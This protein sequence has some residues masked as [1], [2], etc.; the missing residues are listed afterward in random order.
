VVC[1]DHTKRPRTVLGELVCRFGNYLARVFVERTPRRSTW[2]A[3]PSQ[4]LEAARS[5][6]LLKLPVLAFGADEDG[7]ADSDQDGGRDQH[8]GD[9]EE[10]VRFVVAGDDREDD[11]EGGAEKSDDGECSVYWTTP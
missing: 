11:G 10:L 5:N 2:R 6:F 9:G 1:T 4:H 8:F 3:P 7:N